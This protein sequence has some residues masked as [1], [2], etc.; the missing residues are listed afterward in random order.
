[1]R[2]GLPCAVFAAQAGVKPATLAWWKWKLQAEGVVLVTESP[3]KRNG[4]ETRKPGPAF[5]EITPA[6][7]P[8]LARARIELEIGGATLR[9]PDDF[10][11]GTLG[12]LLALLRGTR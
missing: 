11:D 2:S 12:R 3:R 7:G 1:M 5:V 8:E 10:D 6:L 9:V 4:R